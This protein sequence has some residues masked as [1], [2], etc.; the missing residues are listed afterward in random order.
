MALFGKKTESTEA[1]LPDPEK[2][3]AWFDRARQMAESHN[4]ESAFAFFASGFKLDPRDI[5]VHRE[6]LQIASTYYDRGGEP[7]TSKQ[8]KQVD[9][10]SDI[11]KFVTAIFVWWHDITNPKYGMKAI[12]TAVNADQNEYGCEMADVVLSMMQRG[13]TALFDRARQ[14]AESHNYES[15][16]AFFASGFKL[17]PRDIEVHR[18]VLQIAS[19]YYDRGGEPATS[20][21]IKQVDG[22][23]DIEKF[24]TA[25]FVWWH[26]ITNPKY[27]MKAISTAVNADQNE[28]GCEMADVVLSM[29]QR[30]GKTLS[31]KELKNLMVLFKSTDAWD[32]AIKVGQAALRMKP[33]DSVLERE[34][35][36]LSAERAMSEG[37]YEEMGDEEGGFRKFVKD[38]DKQKELEEE[39]SLAG[40]GGSSER[41]LARAK[42]E[43]EDNPSSPDAVTGYVKVLRKQAT[44]ESTKL[45]FQVLMQGFKTTQQYRFRMEA[46]DI[47]IAMGQ[48]QIEQFEQLLS[49]EPTDELR[50]RIETARNELQ[51]FQKNEYE[52]RAAKYPTDRKIR[53]QLGELAMLD[54][55]INLAMECF[56]KAKDEPR[57]RVRAG[58]ELGRC[59]SA[60]GW[61][62][63]AIGE[64]KE[65]IKV[66]AGAD[67]ATELSLR[68]DLMESLSA[69]AKKDG[70]I[71]LAK[72]AMDI[73][74]GIARKDIS[75]RDIRQCRRNLDELVKE[76]D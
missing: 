19:T 8:I 43:F 24:V 1:F 41:V 70:N 12:S 17:D 75:Y 46:A 58:Q 32:Q 60:E 21:Q 64:F 5:E 2:A 25:I 53:F 40:A 62:S 22:S 7:A 50:Q 13:S 48:K 34:L 44:L 4:Y 14:M 49:K 18:E 47:K 59:F 65:S 69:K 74:S 20:K 68:Y 28:Y 57:L 52:E 42:K 6:V 29:M 61:Y 11:E 55:D 26:D 66:L 37:G 45:A 31:H 71:D 73:C 51:E 3:N 76:L 54:G 56:Q 15:A 35:N 39:E 30:G 33:E 23:S 36:E 10:S 67:N 27:G 72:E 63:E 38:M 9:G 16:F